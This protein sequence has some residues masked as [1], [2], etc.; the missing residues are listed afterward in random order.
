VV[1]A[2]GVG[3]G[4]TGKETSSS[5]PAPVFVFV[6]RKAVGLVMK[7]QKLERGRRASGRCQ[8]MFW[9]RLTVSP[10]MTSKLPALRKYR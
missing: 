3:L 8:K 6:T 2:W 5:F 10:A 9:Q 7:K 4:E 1:H